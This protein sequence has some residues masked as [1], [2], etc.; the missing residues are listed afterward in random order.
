[1]VTMRVLI[2]HPVHDD[3]RISPTSPESVGRD[4]TL[5]LAQDVMAAST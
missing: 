1:M 3:E 5:A 2:H 4:R